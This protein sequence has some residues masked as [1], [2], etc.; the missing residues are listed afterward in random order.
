MQEHTS[1]HQAVV[2]A[3]EHVVLFHHPEAFFKRISRFLLLPP[4]RH[5]SLPQDALL[6]LAGLKFL[7]FDAFLGFTFLGF[8]HRPRVPPFSRACRAPQSVRT[9]FGHLAYRWR[10]PAEAR[11]THLPQ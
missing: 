5:C 2:T 7:C 10:Q 3:R 8:T 6:R 9:A 11:K 1:V 4:R